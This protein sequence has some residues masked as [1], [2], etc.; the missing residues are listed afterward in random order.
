MS[1]ATVTFTTP[2][3]FLIIPKTWNSSKTFSVSLKIRTTE[4]NGLLIYSKSGRVIK[5]PWQ[6]NLITMA[7]K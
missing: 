4:P 5:S 7:T 6:L 1:G 2:E 3:S